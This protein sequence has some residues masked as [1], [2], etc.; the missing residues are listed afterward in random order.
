MT[1]QVILKDNFSGSCINPKL[2]WFNEPVHWELTDNKL[3][4][5]TDAKTDFWART[6]YGFI[7][8]NGHC[9]WTPIAENFEMTTTVKFYPA[10]QYDQCGLIIRLSPDCWLKTSVEHE[11]EGPALLGS[12]VTNFGYSDWAT[13][14]APAG[15]NELTLK[16]QR[17]GADFTIYFLA[18]DGHWAQMRVAHLHEAAA[19]EPVFAGLYACSPIDAGYRVEFKHLT[20]TAIP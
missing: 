15:M 19:G 10:H 5:F 12:V 4:L 8:D 13:Q 14:E 6:H 1:E 16:I 20:F 18:A 17:V 2:D 11:P 9:L 3:V 7:N